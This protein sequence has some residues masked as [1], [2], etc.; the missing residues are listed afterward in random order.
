MTKLQTEINISGIPL[1][2]SE[3]LNVKQKD[4]KAP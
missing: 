4:L 2:V 1:A 3:L